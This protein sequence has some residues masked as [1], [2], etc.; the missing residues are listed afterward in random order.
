VESIGGDQAKAT[1]MPE[2][3]AVNPYLRQLMLEVCRT[4]RVIVACRCDCG[5]HLVLTNFEP[6]VLDAQAAGL[7]LLV[8]R[9]SDQVAC[10]ACG[11]SLAPVWHAAEM[12]WVQD[13]LAKL[14]HLDTESLVW[15]LQ[16]E[17][18][19]RKEARLKCN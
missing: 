1:A 5:Q 11:L 13:T 8:V 17:L 19:E 10:P 16:V 2:R 6:S 9:V 15:A 3:C 18:R 14:D 4:E 7:D 12:A